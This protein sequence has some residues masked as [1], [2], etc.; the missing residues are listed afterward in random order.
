MLWKTV[1]NE[2]LLH[3][4][5]RLVFCLSKYQGGEQFRGAREAHG[6]WGAGALAVIR[7]VRADG[8]ARQCSGKGR[9]GPRQ[10]IGLAHVY[11]AAVNGREARDC[12]MNRCYFI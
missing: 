5:R 12:N 1:S 3:V 9:I 7:V 6:R 11:W 10:W 4:R 8:N 2:I